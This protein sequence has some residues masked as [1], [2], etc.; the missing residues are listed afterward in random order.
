MNIVDPIL[1]QSKLNPDGTAICTPG[2]AIESIT[3]GGLERMM[4]NIGQAAMSFGLV[5][6]N[7]VA[8][9]VKEKISHAAIILG[10]MRLGIIAVP[11]RTTRLPNELGVHAVITDAPSL[12]FEN[13]GT[14]ITADPTWMMGDGGPIA[15]KRVDQFAQDDICLIALTSD[16]A[17][18]AK[19]VAFT[20]INLL[21]HLARCAY[22]NG[23][24]FA[25]SPRLYCD[26]GIT[27]S[28][29]IQFM[30]Y[31]LSNGG[32]IYFFGEDP[33]S[34]VQAF[35]LY[36]INNMV[37][38]PAGLTEY[39][40]FFE[41]HSMFQCGFDHI[42]SL[43]LLPKSLS[44]RTR[45]RMTTNLYCSYGAMETGTVALGPAHMIADTPGAVGFITPGAL[46]E[47][48]DDA[49]KVL[50]V[51]KEGF[52]RF[53]TI[54]SVSEYIGNPKESAKVFRDGWFY[55]G[56]I[57]RLTTDRLLIILENKRALQ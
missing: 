12:S 15:D 54:Q 27:T 23:N 14:V 44:E 22:V 28:P 10:L 48:V 4:N 42:L 6:G 3:Y 45:A 20:H 7:V 37:V 36:K 38:A 50:A 32:T 25:Y 57:G 24:R 41:A 40:T 13:A 33:E 29:G 55:S 26:L 31:M 8:I 52:V 43:G 46:V 35:D 18:E 21:G 16:T 1:F 47:I 5:R 11:T 51:G 9:H 49:D 30:L 56:D 17:S 19:G 39:V 34:I 53:R 2:A